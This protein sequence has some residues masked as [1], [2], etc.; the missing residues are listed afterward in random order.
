MAVLN[1]EY[2]QRAAILECNPHLRQEG[3]EGEN[4]I[5]DGAAFRRGFRAMAGKGNRDLCRETRPAEEEH[6]LPRIT[7]ESPAVRGN[8]PTL[9][10]GFLL[11]PNQNSRDH[12][13]RPNSQN[14]CRK[15]RQQGVVEL[16]EDR[17]PGKR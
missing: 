2:H 9:P 8:P 6:M 11:I 15:L 10:V 14:G 7:P 12:H 16:Y 13:H 17:L 1:R 3:V 5:R 4:G